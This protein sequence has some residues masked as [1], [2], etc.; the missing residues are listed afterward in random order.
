MIE[1]SW[2]Y[3]VKNEILQRVEEEGNILHRRKRKKASWISHNLRRNCFLKHV[4]EEKTDEAGRRG[5]RYKQLLDNFKEK[6][7]YWKL[8]EGAL[9][10][11]N[12]LWKAIW[13]RL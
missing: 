2:N 5:R 7:S 10:L 3:L 4:I 1:I 8:K 6:I 12:S 13:T 9:Y 11:E